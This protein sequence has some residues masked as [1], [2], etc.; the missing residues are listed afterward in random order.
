VA[1]DLV[2]GAQRAVLSGASHLLGSWVHWTFVLA[3]GL[4]G[5]FRQPIRVVSAFTLGQVAGALAAAL[6]PSVRPVPAEIGLAVAVVL[7]AREALRPGEERRRLSA[8]AGAAGLVHGLGNAALLAGAL[9]DDAAHLVSQLLAILGMDAAHL[10]G[11]LAAAALWSRVTRGF[12]AVRMREGVVY[13][14][15][16]TGMALA[17]G[18]AVGGG[19]VESPAVASS[20]PPPGQSAASPT[21]GVA[22]SRRVA[23]AVP[24]AP[25]QSFLAVEPFEIRHEAMLRLGGLA[26]ELGLD[27]ASTLEI[28]SQPALSERLVALVVGR[29][30]VRADGV[31]IQGLVRR[32]NF[33]TVDPTGALPRT[34][35]VPESVSQAVVGAVVAYPTAGMPREVSMSWDPFPDSVRTIPATVIDPESVAS[36][37][38]SAGEPSLTWENTLLEDPIPSVAAVEVESVMMPIPLLS[39]PLLALAA[40]VLIAGIRR[41]RAEVSVATAR[42]VLALALVAGPLAQTAVALPGSTGWAPS[43]RQARRILSGLLPNIYRAM[44][45]REEAVIYDRLA[46][47]VTG[48]TLAGVYLEQRRALEM[49]ERGGARARVEAVEILEAREIESRDTG[50]GVHSI[51]TVGGMVTH[52][53]HRH[54]RQNRYDA[55]I[56]VVPVAGMWKIQSIEV[57]EQ[58]RVR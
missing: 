52:F 42:V 20:L 39:L 48:E 23:P 45:F 22:G 7:L 13:G 54:F 57:L 17:I 55:R 38:L 3:I 10:L 31:R 44:E 16:A 15:G 33:M 37:T 2:R 21:A 56:A 43:E 12:V 28:A 27:P 1:P 14:A 34:T 35:P 5:G 8:L 25:I 41:R 18:L 24:D 9:G 4:I 36:L 26:E 46:V 11:A 40:V 6:V 49:E 53:G 32:A 58:D 47:S 29:T 19:V 50:F 30:T 51:W